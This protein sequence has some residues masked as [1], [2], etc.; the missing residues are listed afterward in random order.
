MKP[1][2]FKA[3]SL[4]GLTDKKKGAQIARPFGHFV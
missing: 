1:E 2:Y 3:W 4:S